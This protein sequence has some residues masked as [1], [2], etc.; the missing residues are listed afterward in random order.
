MY[1]MAADR[2]L[3]QKPRKTAPL[4]FKARIESMEVIKRQQGD[5]IPFLFI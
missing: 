3:E 1:A 2:N 5:A 4:P